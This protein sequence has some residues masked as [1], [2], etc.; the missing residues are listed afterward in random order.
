[1]GKLACSSEKKKDFKWKKKNDRYT[2]EKK[3]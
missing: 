2:A 3:N 1:M